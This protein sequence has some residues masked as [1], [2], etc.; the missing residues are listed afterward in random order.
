MIGAL[1]VDLMPSCSDLAVAAHWSKTY[2]YE[3]RA[4]QAGEVR[5]GV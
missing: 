2:K 1:C 4:S 5:E 3:A